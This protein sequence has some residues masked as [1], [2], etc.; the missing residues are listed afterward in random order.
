LGGVVDRVALAADLVLYRWVGVVLVG[1]VDR[2]FLVGVV[3]LVYSGG[4]GP[5]R[6]EG[7]YRPTTSPFEAR[8]RTGGE[9]PV[10]VL[11]ART[12]RFGPRMRTGGGE[13]GLLEPQIP[14]CCCCCCFVD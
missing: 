3:D 6:A 14:I 13:W 11:R 8:M 2:V 9:L 7:S 10:G 12:S 4:M 5:A 1:V